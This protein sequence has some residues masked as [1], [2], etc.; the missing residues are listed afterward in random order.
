MLWDG[1]YWVYFDNSL[2]KTVVYASSRVGD[3]GFIAFV[4][5]VLEFDF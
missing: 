1:L 3:V 4:F 2:T 5:V